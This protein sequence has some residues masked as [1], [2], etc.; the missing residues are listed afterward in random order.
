MYAADA[1]PFLGSGAISPRFSASFARGVGHEVKPL[2]DVRCADAVCSQ[3]R[4]PDGV[5]FGFHVCRNKI[6][7]SVPNRCANL[8]AKHDVRTALAD[9][10]E[11]RR[12]E[13]PLI[14]KP[15]S[16]TC[17]AERLA[18][19]RT[20]PNGHISRPSGKIKGVGPSADAGEKVALGISAKLIGAHVLY[21]SFVNIA[22]RNAALP[23]Q[24]TQPGGGKL[25]VFVVVVH[26][27]RR[28]CSPIVVRPDCP[29]LI[30]HSRYQLPRTAFR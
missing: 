8:L 20:S 15:Q 22:G 9:E 17:R 12:P 4:C 7:P 29:S 19:T 26:A 11:P 18:R 30:H 23:D 2:P 13:M 25:V 6:E 1:I 5:T 27:A 21:R 28:A 16:F 14:C 3:Y 24:F 10:V